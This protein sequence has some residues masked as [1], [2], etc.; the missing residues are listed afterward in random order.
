M[1]PE[2]R[3]VGTVVSVVRHDGGVQTQGCLYRPRAGLLLIV[4][5]DEREM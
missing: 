5:A 4:F 1:Q 2:T 3:V